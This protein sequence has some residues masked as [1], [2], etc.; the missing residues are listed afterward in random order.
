ML[1]GRGPHGRFEHLLT[2]RA[3][4]IIFGVGSG[5]GEV[6]GH[7]EV[8]NP[9]SGSRR[10]GGGGGGSGGGGGGGSPGPTS[11]REPGGGGEARQEAARARN[12]A[13]PGR[14]EAERPDAKAARAGLG[15]RPL[16]L[17]LLLEVGTRRHCL[18]EG[19]GRET[20]DWLH[21]HFCRGSEH[22][23][24]RPFRLGMGARCSPLGLPEA[25]LVPGSAPTA[26][27]APPLRLPFPGF[28]PFDQFYP[29]WLPAATH[30]PAAP[31]PAAW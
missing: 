28:S 23:R 15:S 29:L 11:L 17:L 31:C 24:R 5:R 10:G 9:G 12:W 6:L 22:A 7:G 1:T 13:G 4:E 8:E 20:S 25:A 21:F 19:G 18:T 26:L 3:V 14:G 2:D 16:G 30:F 27:F